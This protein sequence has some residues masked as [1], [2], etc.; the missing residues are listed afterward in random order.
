VRRKIQPGGGA[1]KGYLSFGG[2]VAWCICCSL[3]LHLL[4]APAYR[5]TSISPTL[6]PASSTVSDGMA[7]GSMLLAA[8]CFA[9]SQRTLLSHIA[10]AI[11]T[12]KMGRR[13]KNIPAWRLQFRLWRGVLSAFLAVSF[14]VLSLVRVCLSPTPCPKSQFG[15]S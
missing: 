6:P 3:H 5:R 12:G 8:S 1:R 15:S 11:A 10:Q 9:I 2:V 4:F 14:F 7:T 13:E